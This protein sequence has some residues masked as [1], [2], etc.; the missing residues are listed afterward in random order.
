MQEGKVLMQLLNIQTILDYISTGRY[1]LY[2]RSRIRCFLTSVHTAIVEFSEATH[3]YLSTVLDTKSGQSEAA[4]GLFRLHCE[5]VCPL[6]RNPFLFSSIPIS[7]SMVLE[8]DLCVR[9]LKSRWF[10]F[11]SLPQK[12]LTPTIQGFSLGFAAVTLTCGA[13]LKPCSISLSCAKAS[14]AAS[15]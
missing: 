8:Y 9:I 3:P 10:P 2:I 13:V 14:G 12:L 4:D 1:F 11:H 5:I 6:V 7:N 15:R